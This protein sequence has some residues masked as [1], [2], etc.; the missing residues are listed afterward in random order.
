MWDEGRIQVRSRAPD[1]GGSF[2]DSIRAF[3][4]MHLP[5]GSAPALISG[6]YFFV[7][8]TKSPDFLGAEFVFR[9]QTRFVKS[10]HG[11]PIEH[12]CVSESSGNLMN[13]FFYVAFENMGLAHGI[14]PQKNSLHSVS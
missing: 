8:L 13:G 14:S 1:E 9:G 11:L 7:A 10:Q 5:P 4:A 12:R 2:M 6:S 3:G